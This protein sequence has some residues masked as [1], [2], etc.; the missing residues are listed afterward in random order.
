MIL[1]FLMSNQP[2]ATLVEKGA[3]PSNQGKRSILNAFSACSR[4]SK[5][6]SDGG[7]RSEQN[8]QMQEKVAPL[9]FQWKPESI[10]EMED[11]FNGLVI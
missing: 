1:P 8:I 9:S 10:V 11:F 3:A 5:L 4:C 7:N 6:S 2:S